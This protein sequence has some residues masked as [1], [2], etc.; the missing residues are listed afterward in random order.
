ME[1]TAN[2]KNRFKFNSDLHIHS[3]ISSCSND[4]R[5]SKEKILEYAKQNNL[6]KIC[7]TDHFWD[8][9]VEGGAGSWYE[10]Q[11][12]EHI[13]AALP[14]PQEDSIEFLFGCE[15]EMDKFFT[16]GISKERF[17]EFDF[18]IVPTTHMHFM[19][20]TIASEDDTFERRAKL[21]VERFDALLNMDLPFHKM[22][23][24]H[25]TCSLIAR[26]R[27]D[28]LEVLKLIPES[29]M[30]RLFKKAAEV[31]IGIEINSSALNFESEEEAEIAIKPYKIAKKYGCKFYTGSD[32]HH[33]EQFEIAESVIGRIIDML[34]LTEDDKFDM[35][36]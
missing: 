14:L 28:Y 17:D 1:N 29:E 31:G 15:T 27:E 2:N 20:F 9:A 12:F 23:L 32:A 33:P 35:A 5:Q 30:E 8:D 34:D 18:V 4:E 22:G 10:K 24:A 25:I 19:N 3:K 26:K 7:L 6:K 16:L 13:A 36:K 21:W 11:N